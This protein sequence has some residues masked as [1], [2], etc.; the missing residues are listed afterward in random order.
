MIE[1]KESQSDMLKRG[2]DWSLSKE[3]EDW[4]NRELDNKQIDCLIEIDE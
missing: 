2:I 3:I 4:S 1:Q